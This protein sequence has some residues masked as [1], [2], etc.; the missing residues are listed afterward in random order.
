M[1]LNKPTIQINI[2]N[3]TNSRNSELNSVNATK[4]KVKINLSKGF[5]KINMKPI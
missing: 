1:T 5:S 3:V 2:S 4:E